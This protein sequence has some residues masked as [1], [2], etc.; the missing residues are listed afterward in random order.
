MTGSPFL[1]LCLFCLSVVKA[2]SKMTTK[3][4]DR[5][6]RKA[7]GRE[8]KEERERKKKVEDKKVEKRRQIE[9]R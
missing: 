5:E 1:T 8:R 3:R 2:F 9:R 6:C 4:R 7:D